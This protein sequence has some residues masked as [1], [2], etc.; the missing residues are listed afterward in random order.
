M[1]SS[2]MVVGICLAGSF[3]RR[4]GSGSSLFYGIF[5][6]L[7][8]IYIATIGE[9]LIC[10]ILPMP[11]NTI[12]FYEFQ[13]HIMYLS[14]FSLLL[15]AGSFFRGFTNR[16][17]VIFLSILLLFLGPFLDWIPMDSIFNMGLSLYQHKLIISFI[18]IGTILY[19]LY[20]IY[21]ALRKGLDYAGYI[22]ITVTAFLCYL[23]SLLLDFLFYVNVGKVPTV[24]MLFLILAQIIFIYFR[25]KL[26]FRK[27]DEL[28]SQLLAY[29]RMKDKFLAKTSLEL[30]QP[31]NNIISLS[32]KL[33]KGN[34]GPL[35]LYQ[36]QRIMQ[37]GREGKHIYGVLDEMLE[38]SG[39]NGDLKIFRENINRGALEDIIEELDYLVYERKD[40][41]ILKN[42]PPDFPGI[43]SDKNKLRKILYH[44]LHN[45]VKFTERGEIEVS[46]EVHG[47]EA[48]LSVRDTGPGIPK[49]LKEIIFVPFYQGKKQDGDKTDGLGLGLGITKNLVEGLGG[50]IWVVSEQGKGSRFTFSMPLAAGNTKDKFREALPAAEELQKEEGKAAGKEMPGTGHKEEYVR[51]AG[52]KEETI[53]IGTGD[54]L[55]PRELIRLNS[56]EKYGLIV[57]K[58]F[59][60]VL[61][62]V[63]KEEVA[64]IIL[65]LSMDNASGYEAC[66]KIR[67]HYTMT[68]L[69]VIIFT[70][71]GQAKE[72]QKSVRSGAN[73]F[74]RKPY[75]WEEVKARIETLLLVR[76]SAKEALNQEHKNL[77]AQIMPHFLYNTLNTIIGL[78]YKDTERACEALGH[79]STYF[80]AKLDFESYHSFV[81]IDREVEL[82]KAYLAIEKIRY[83]ERLE[84]IYD[85]DESLDFRLPALTLQPL[86]ENSVQH[87]IRDNNNKVTVQITMEKT[88]EGSV[89]IQIKDDGPGMSK[90]KQEELLGEKNQRIGFSN[91]LR[92]IR[93]MKNSDLTLE[94]AEGKGTCI[95]ICL[96]DIEIHK[97]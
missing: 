31:V 29:D 25:S 16:K 95:T 4:K 64:L 36:Q 88:M 32:E 52:G 81:P 5:I 15:L 20:V 39:E 43:W 94:S 91:V 13:V 48:F 51:L 40:L 90:A 58:S 78:S 77:H 72:L 24:M 46:A 71:G 47:S 62:F 11:K 14:L 83:D 18:T 74:I 22:I 54:E 12:L 1:T 92:K 75:P 73:D 65:D 82:M 3:F 55:F 79:L 84:I 42:I 33:L 26:A 63:L 49:N 6:I 9:R 76:N 34:G 86:V 67:E 27:V 53:L 68:E 45:A 17:M 7:Q 30:Q 60:K 10:D 35:S 38:A 28:S 66:R 21:R 50:R 56:E 8:G 85:L 69:P 2:C 80:R 57:C 59:D 93:L 23:T 70:D 97:A 41:N 37:I 89:V 44:L 61:E 96:K 19:I 87:G